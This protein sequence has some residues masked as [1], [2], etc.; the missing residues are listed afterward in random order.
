MSLAIARTR[1][2]SASEPAPPAASDSGSC[3]AVGAV[4]GVGTVR[5][6]PSRALNHASKTWS[7]RTRSSGP[8]HRVARPAHRVASTSS[9]PT[10]DVAARKVWARSEVTPTPAARSARVKASR[11][12]SAP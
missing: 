8:A 4:G 10:T 2:A 6:R 5:G 3:D 9:S 11:I 7:K 1:S 12:S